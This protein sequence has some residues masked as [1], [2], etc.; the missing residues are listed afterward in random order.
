MLK[1][2]VND[3]ETL[4]VSEDKGHILVNNEPFDWNLSKISEKD[5]HILK[6]NRSY[7]VE[8]VEANYAEKTFKL[9]I[10]GTIHTVNLK[11]RTDLLLEKM[12]MSSNKSTRL[13]NLKAPMPGLIYEMKVQVGD[14]VKKGDVL[15]ILVAMKMEN[16]IKAAGDGKVKTIKVKTG[17]TVEKNQVIMEFE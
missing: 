8:V 10:G 13:N 4:E 17:E 2:I 1:A 9:K 15:L 3:T 16:A 11:D 12:G 6:D 5:F 7:N 14:E